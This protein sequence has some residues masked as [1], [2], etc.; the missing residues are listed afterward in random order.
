VDGIV[1]ASILDATN[2]LGSVMFRAYFIISYCLATVA[3]TG[4]QRIECI[5]DVS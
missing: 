5:I 3:S 1:D 4:M 2:I